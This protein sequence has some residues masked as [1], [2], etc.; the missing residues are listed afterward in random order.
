MN[1]LIIIL[2]LLPGFVWLLF[3]LNEDANPEPKK[4]IALVF[5]A[6][7]ISAV[8]AYFLQLAATCVITYHFADCRR[9]LAE[10]EIDLTPTLILIFAAVEE[11][12][13]FGAVWFTAART[14]YFDE[15]IDAMI[16][17]AVAALG[18]ATVENLGALFGITT[19]PFMDGIF[20]TAAFRLV[21]TTLLHTL[22]ASIVGYF[23]ALE[24]RNFK[25]GKFL[26]YGLLLGITLH[27]IFNYLI[28]IY[29]NLIYPIIFVAIAGFFVLGDFD[30]LKGKKL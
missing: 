4:I 8:V 27:V 24:I 25:S 21:G 28:L 16:Y 12:V 22:T 18:F 29:S 13:K 20:E 9:N 11:F 30:K 17:M 1:F 26:A 5:A 14:K 7:I 19:E 15:P 3:Y 23:W 10:N 2:G 6:G